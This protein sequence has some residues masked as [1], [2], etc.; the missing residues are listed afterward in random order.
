MSP[1]HPEPPSEKVAGLHNVHDNDLDAS[2]RTTSLKDLTSPGV[3]RVEALSASLTL[4]DRVSIFLSVF[5]IA[6]A[7]SLDGTLRYTYQP[8]AAASFSAH[9]LQSTINVVRA[10]IAAG[11][12]PVSA[13]VADVFGRVEL[14]CVSILLY[15]LGTVVESV[16]NSV[17]AFA[18]GGAIYQIGYT[19]IILLVEVIIADITSTRARL[20]LSYIPA[21]PFI[22]NTWVSGNIAAAVLNATTWRWGIAMWCII[23]PV[24]ALPLIFNLWRV[25]RRAKKQ[26]LLPDYRSS[27][28]QLGFRGLVSKLFWL[29]DVVGLVLVLA[30][31]ALILVPF[32]LAGGFKNKWQSASVIAPLVVG[33]L[34]IPAFVIWE[35]RAPH[36]LVPF[37]LMKDRGVWAPVGIAIFLMFAFTMQNDYLFTVLQVAFGFDVTAATR[38]TSVYSFVSVI[39]GPIVGLVVY[40]VRRLKIFVIAGTTLYMVAFGLLIHFRGSPSGSARSGVIGAQVLLG[41]AGGLFPYT[42]QASLQVALRHENLAVMTGIYLA[43][44]NIGSA[45]GNAVSGALWTQL[46]PSKLEQ[47]LAN[48]NTTLAAAAYENPFAN[49]VAVYPLGTPERTAVIDAYQSIQRILCITGIC[50]CVPLIFFALMLRNPKLNNNQTLASGNSTAAETDRAASRA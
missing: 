35:L 29:L 40:F 37:S 31:F 47:T 49:V 9:S 16:S 43:L 11:M 27:F 25:S 48:V 50:L 38:I 45:L 33:V 1:S 39:V 7:Y 19:M 44:Y 46:L 20:F 18:V 23:Y 34:C 22:I 12:Q 32:T 26:G 15:V 36:P 14:L 42:A 24:C 5:L 2:S 41:I 13:K 30:L 17:E 4:T 21:L 6:Y 3:T 28:E 10:V 8:L